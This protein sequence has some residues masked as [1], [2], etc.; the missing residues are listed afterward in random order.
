M[1]SIIGWCAIFACS[2]LVFLLIFG[3]GKLK[4]TKDDSDTDKQK[5][6]SE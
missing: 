2:Y 5:D 3:P 1:K 6:D 4:S